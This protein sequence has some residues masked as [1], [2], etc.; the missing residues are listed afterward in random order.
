MGEPVKIA[1][2]VGNLIKYLGYTVREIGIE[3]SGNRS[4]E[5][6]YDELIKMKSKMNILIQK[7]T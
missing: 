5:K 3:F 4:G 6:M 1:D 7:I 2:L